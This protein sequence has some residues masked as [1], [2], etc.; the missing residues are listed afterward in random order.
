MLKFL[1]ILK[2]IVSLK[3]KSSKLY[4]VGNL[5]QFYSQS[6]GTWIFW[7]FYFWSKLQI[8]NANFDVKLNGA[9]RFVPHRVACAFI[10]IKNSYIGKIRYHWKY[11]ILD[12]KYVFICIVFTILGSGL[13]QTLSCNNIIFGEDDS[14]TPCFV[15]LSYTQI[16]LSQSDYIMKT[17]A[18]VFN[19][20]IGNSV[21][22]VCLTIVRVVP[23]HK[24]GSE[25]ADKIFR[26]ISALSFIG[27]L[28]KRLI[29]SRLK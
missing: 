11:A 7:R 14:I 9:A 22:L 5:C 25:I 17:L 19:A 20:S 8:Q 28:F 3:K 16:P 1:R 15:L 24:S 26:P 2:L 21:F 27:K 10:F 13:K 18:S 23:I 4:V 6:A 29:H 12:S